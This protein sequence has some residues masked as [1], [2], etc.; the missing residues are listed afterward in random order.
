MSVFSRLFT[1][2]C[3]PK[4]KT[5]EALP[6]EDD[7]DCLDE[8][9]II[10]W[11]ENEDDGSNVQTKLQ[12][13]RS[14]SS[15]I[16]NCANEKECFDIMMK[17][18]NE[19]AFVIMTGRF[20]DET[21]SRVHQWKQVD[22][23]YLYSRNDENN[24][25]R[26]EKWYKVKNTSSNISAIGET[27]QQNLRQC[28]HN[29]I[30][31]S[32]VKSIGS[33]TTTQCLDEQN[34]SFMNTLL[35]RRILLQID[36]DK[37]S[38][39]EFADYYE[40]EHKKKLE[41]YDQD[42]QEPKD[43]SKEYKRVLE[44]LKKT[45]EFRKTYRKN[46]AIKWYSDETFMYKTLNHA[47]RLMDIGTLMRF[48]FF[49]K[50]LHLQ[51]D[52]LRIKQHKNGRFP[53]LFEVYRGQQLSKDSLDRLRNTSNEYLSFNN[54]LSTSLERKTAIDFSRSATNPDLHRV[55]FIMQI[56]PT[57]GS[58]PFAAV[59]DISACDGEDEVLFSM[60]TVFRIQGVKA[61]NADNDYW[62]IRLE[63]VD[64]WDHKLNQLIQFSYEENRGL[65]LWD[66]L[67]RFFIMTG[68]LNK[69]EK[70]YKFLLRK[71][72]TKR[73]EA[74]CYNQLGQ[75]KDRL[76]E[77]DAAIAYLE[78]CFKILRSTSH[79]N[80]ADLASCYTNI[81]A[82]HAHTRDY[83]NA[84]K[85]HQ[86]ALKIRLE[87]QCPDQVD[88]ASCYYNMGFV[89][90]DMGDY[91]KA[92]THFE[93]ALILRRKYLPKNHRDICQAEE[94]LLSV[95]NQ[96]GVQNRSYNAP[97]PCY[98][99]PI[100]VPLQNRCFNQQPYR[101][102]IVLNDS[103][104]NGNLAPMQ[105]ILNKQ[106]SHIQYLSIPSADCIQMMTNSILCQIR[107]KVPEEDA[108][109][110]CYCLPSLIRQI[111]CKSPWLTPNDVIQWLTAD[112][113]KD[114]MIDTG[115]NQI[116]EPMHSHQQQK[117]D[118]VS[119][120]SPDSLSSYQGRHSQESVGSGP[121]FDSPITNHTDRQGKGFHHESREP[122][123]RKRINNARSSSTH[124]YQSQHL[125][126]DSLS[127]ESKLSTKERRVPSLNKKTP[128][129]DDDQSFSS[130]SIRSTNSKNTIEQSRVQP[131]T[132]TS[133]SSRI[134]LDFP[135]KKDPNAVRDVEK[136]LAFYEKIRGYF[137]DDVAAML[138][139]CCLC[140]GHCSGNT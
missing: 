88:L 99:I 123:S 54:F 130:H 113:L 83:E 97:K 103:C 9:G 52:A 106:T 29:S 86:A 2:I 60:H 48:G 25:R 66:N 41:L 67:G 63:L 105:P 35:L 92:C 110:L 12:E 58:T 20:D 101:C 107:C 85:Y 82:V 108:R 135:G 50:D 80:P 15:R 11:L 102:D 119:N 39:K 124:S 13:S 57:L 49:L 73:E 18:P 40:R 115:D 37:T 32:Q 21:V 22:S 94:Q 131:K 19:R 8:D 132:S 129:H 112:I 5:F 17:Y 56:D 64:A 59:E 136:C 75:I 116:D 140:Y 36:F 100:Q 68:N 121:N 47:L 90:K 98:N 128:V 78:Q 77:Y 30:P 43:D 1:G 126:D 91:A 51:I 62:E 111:M 109:L 28:A 46:D 69:A 137:D 87:A 26:S 95:R 16:K 133:P 31:I 14:V 114:A 55:L 104:I 7:D 10:I 122:Q 89:C 117:I 79:E 139:R 53:K 81:G 72:S 4:S 42:S 38:V 84:F 33:L 93:K 71:A 34:I 127:D 76:S 118:R 74:N 138:L 24:K 44:D 125:N 120:N 27:V 70:L 6:I 96:L 23:I 65:S 3:S 45:V 134:R 61:P